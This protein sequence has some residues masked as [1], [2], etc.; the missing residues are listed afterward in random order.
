MQGQQGGYTG[1][2]DAAKTQPIRIITL[3]YEYDEEEERD[4]PVGYEN[5]FTA[6]EIASHAAGDKLNLYFWE[7]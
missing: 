4:V 5:P 3:I 7:S 2:W 6:E 1:Y